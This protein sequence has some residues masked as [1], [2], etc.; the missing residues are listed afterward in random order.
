MKVVTSKYPHKE[1][2]MPKNGY[3]HVTRDQRCQIYALMSRGISFHQI[4]K[5]IGLSPSTISREVKRNAGQRGYRQDQADK[6][7]AERRS[8]ASRQPKKMTKELKSAIVEKIN[9]GWSPEQ[10]SGRL[11]LDNFAQI[12]HEAIYLFIWADKKQGGTLFAFLRHR[13]KPYNRRRNKKAG[14]GC[15]PNR[16]DIDQ[17]PK[18]VETKSRLGDW[19]GDTIIGAHHK[20][21]IVTLVCRKSKLSVLQKVPAKTSKLVALAIKR[22]LA[23]LKRRVFSITFDNGKE[24]ADHEGISSSLNTKCFFAKPYHSWERGLN[25]HTNG[26][27]RQYLPKKTDFRTISQKTITQIEDSLNHRPRKALNFKTPHEVF[28]G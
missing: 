4:A 13:A 22:R 23:K 27:I 11:K 16:V 20:G 25:E 7:A 1:V 2:I 3:K 19:E 18:V 24:F 12:S 28:Y 10:I 15:I 6:I 26:L 9:L 14:R 8:N 21:A 17:R 5:Q